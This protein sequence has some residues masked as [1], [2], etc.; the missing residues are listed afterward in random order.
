[1]VAA[2]FCIPINS[3]QGKK[4]VQG[5]PF[6]HIFDIAY[7]P[8]IYRESSPDKCKVIAHCDSY[9]YFPND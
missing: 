8:F 5:F 9:L 7:C 1:M 4:S 3:V 6:L 2:P